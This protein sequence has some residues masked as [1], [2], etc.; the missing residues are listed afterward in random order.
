MDEILH[1]PQERETESLTARLRAENPDASL[2]EL[3]RLHSPPITK[4]GLNHRLPK[5]I[6]EAERH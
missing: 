5:L 2:E 1:I 4:S 6:E 3:R